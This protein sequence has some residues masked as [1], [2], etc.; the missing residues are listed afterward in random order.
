M[1]E[2]VINIIPFRAELAEH[3]TRLNTA[4]VQK[5]FT[6]EPMDKEMLG[7]P[8]GYIIDKGNYIFFATINDAITGTFALIKESGQVYQLS[9]MA[10]DENY[11]GQKI[12]NRLLE[13]CIEKAKELK[14]HKLTLYSNTILLP[15]IHLY[16]KYGFVQVPL[17]HSEFKRSNIK[18]ELVIQ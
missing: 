15:A 13:F 1:S 3:F 14:A 17:E 16:K 2:S 9:K 18:M 7:N 12:G 11:Q 8:K 10:V 5:Y 4:W 6:L